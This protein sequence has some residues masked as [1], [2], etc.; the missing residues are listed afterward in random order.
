VTVA[1]ASV[2]GPPEPKPPFVPAIPAP[3]LPGPVVPT[4]ANGGSPPEFVLGFAFL[5][6]QLG[7]TMGTPLEAEHGVT[8]SCDT[9]QLTSTGLAYWRCS[10]N[11]MT[12][13]ADPDGLVHWAWLDQLVT[14]R[15]EAADPPA[16]AVAVASSATTLR[17]LDDACISAN[18]CTLA[19]GVSMDGYIESSGQSNAYRFDVAGPSMHVTAD[20]TNLPADYDLYLVDAAGAAL[21]QS[22]HEDVA[23]EEIDTMLGPGTYYLFVHSDPGR[24]FDGDNPYTLHLSVLPANAAAALP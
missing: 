6:Q 21:E 15:G 4:D 1:G 5:K 11:T 9:Q 7:P 13:A 24:P 3:A 22:I 12:F 18:A 23:P 16:D 17:P 2:V 10:T 8:D 19:N 20:L 14:W